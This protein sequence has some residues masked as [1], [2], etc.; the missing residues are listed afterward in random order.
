MTQMGENH[1]KAETEMGVKPPLAKERRE[2]PEAQETR[3]IL[4]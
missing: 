2:P 3:R 1:V 4:P